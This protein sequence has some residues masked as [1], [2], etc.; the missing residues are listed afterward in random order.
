MDGNHLRIK[1][2]VDSWPGRPGRCEEEEK[3]AGRLIF[4]KATVTGCTLI[5]L[6]RAYSSK[7]R[8]IALTLDSKIS[9]F[10]MFHRLTENVDRW[11][12]VFDS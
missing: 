5:S 9:S 12:V 8:T 11:I 7:E 6:S 1:T 3:A 4:Q 10:D 2:F